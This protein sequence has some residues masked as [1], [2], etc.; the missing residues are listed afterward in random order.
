MTAMATPLIPS[1]MKTKVSK[2]KYIT[3]QILV[4]LI[5]NAMFIELFTF[6]RFFMMLPD[7]NTITIKTGYRINIW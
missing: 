6:S 7:I 4:E 3:R 5:I 2:Y 1:S